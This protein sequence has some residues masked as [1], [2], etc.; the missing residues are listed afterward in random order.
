[1]TKPDTYILIV[2]TDA[3][4]VA[5]LKPFLQ[6]SFGNISWAKS[7]KQAESILSTQPIDLILLET[8]LDQPDAGLQWCRQLQTSKRF[9]TT[10]VF[11]LSSADEQFHLDLKG[12]LKDP[13][14]CPAAD[15]WDKA[16]PPATIVER[17]EKYLRSRT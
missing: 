10:A 1:M 4:Y 7:I 14:Y 9:D 11:I 2:D 8:I 17:L 6:S 3:D 5:S 16:T 12:K 13:G 15:F